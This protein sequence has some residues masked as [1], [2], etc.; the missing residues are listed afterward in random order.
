MLF[1]LDPFKISHASDLSSNAKKLISSTDEG[2]LQLELV[3]MQCS[4]SLKEDFQEGGAVKSWTESIQKDQFPNARKVAI[5]I[6]TM[7]GSTYTKSCESSFSHMNAI[8]TNTR[9]SMS[10]DRLQ[11]S[12]RIALTSFQSNLLK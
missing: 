1:F 10:N 11:D 9:S 4:N 12:M 7:F 3:D 6:L 2:S 5:F 8:K